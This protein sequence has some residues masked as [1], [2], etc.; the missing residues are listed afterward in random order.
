MTRVNAVNIN[1]TRDGAATIQ[2]SLMHVA[3]LA[4]QKS[5]TG[6][7]EE[8]KVRKTHWWRNNQLMHL[9]TFK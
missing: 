5:S 7:E 8:E 3:G 9:V 6:L 2:L 4:V 1:I